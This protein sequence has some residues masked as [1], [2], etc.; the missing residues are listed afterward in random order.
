MLREGLHALELGDSGALGGDRPPVKAS[1][2]GPGAGSPPAALSGYTPLQDKVHAVDGRLAGALADWFAGVYAVEAVP[3]AAQR[4][5]PGFSALNVEGT[6]RHPA[7]GEAWEYSM[8]VTIRNGRGEE[9]ARQIIGVGAIPPEE[10][11]TFT[12]AV[13]VSKPGEGK[14]S[15]G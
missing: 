15:K 5:A 12:L 4:A 7:A 10:S 13:E 14:P 9:V 6:I 1:L 8:V 2:F 3:G 11:R